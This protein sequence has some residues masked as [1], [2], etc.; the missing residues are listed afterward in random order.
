MKSESPQA[1]WRSEKQ[2]AYLYSE[3]A[4]KEKGNP[5]GDLFAKLSDEA[6][7]QA[8]LWAQKLPASDRAKLTYSPSLKALLLRNL[9]RTFGPKPLLRPLAAAKIRGLSI[10]T[11]APTSHH[12][13]TSDPTQVG[14]H[15]GTSHASWLRASIFGAND[16][17][18]SNASLILG[19]AG[20]ASDSKTLLL[21]GTAGLLAGAFSM[22]C[23]E[24]ISVRT[25]REFLERQLALEEAELK[26]YP[27]EEAEELAMIYIARGMEPEVAH[28][29]A[30]SIITRPDQALL[31]LAREELGIDPQELGSPWIAAG[32]SFV[33]FAVG[34]AIPLLPFV[35]RL[36]GQPL[37]VAVGLSALSL[38]AIGA[39]IS[40]FTGRNAWYGG[41]RMLLIGSLGGAIT[42]AVGHLLGAVVS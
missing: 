27:E 12:A 29:A 41:A 31:A 7:K 3:L 33:A 23:G 17:L 35:V 15:H 18:V 22:A 11:E 38:A 40:L 10:Y 19:F 24:Y 8:E 34:A 4:I 1:G 28:R 13:I 2:S 25:Q 39:G 5:G 20:A 32:S 16:G 36:P 9:I 30:Q 14:A 42:F 6:N 26:T 37:Q 21:S